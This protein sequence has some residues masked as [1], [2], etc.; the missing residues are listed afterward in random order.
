MRNKEEIKELL[1]YFR[2]IENKD[3]TYDEKAILTA[4]EKNETHQ[5]L[6]IKIL[7]IF[8]GIL[9]SLSFL[10]F[11]FLIGL[12]DSTTGILTL[13]IIAIA[14]GVFI[15]KAYDKIIIDTISVSSYLMG[16]ILLAVG[17]SKLEVSENAVSLISILIAAASLVM[18]RSYIIA[19]ISVLIINGGILTL[20]ASNKDF[21]MIHLY[22]SFLAI[23]LTAVFLKEAKI[24][25]KNITFSKLYNPVRIGLVFSFLAGLIFL[26]NDFIEVS[27]DYIW[28]SSVVIILAIMYVLS[29]IFE[30]LNISQTTQKA[31]IY[32]VTIALLLPTI[33]SPAISGSILIILLSFLVNYKTSLAIG[34]MAFIYF[35]S[36]YYYDLHFTLLTKSILL[37]SS[38]IL[39]LGLYLL[40]RKKL[41]SNEKV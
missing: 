17:L 29:Q 2:T 26:G 24:I 11:L 7:S 35:V 39:F 4:Y 28:I 19:F 36:R 16:F 12:Y 41:T 6:A 13:A 21:D 37:F 40:T 22:T 30:V 14:A 34:I 18:V 32:I 1:D 15:N 9:A 33:L 10:G 31:G 20:I 5:S 38:G 3:F 8:G 23:M 27:R 25:S